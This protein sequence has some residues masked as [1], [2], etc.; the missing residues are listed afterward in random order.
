MYFIYIRQ[1][2]KHPTVFEYAH[3]YLDRGIKRTSAENLWL[4]HQAEFLPWLKVILIFFHSKDRN[5]ATSLLSSWPLCP[6]PAE[7]VSE[8]NLESKVQDIG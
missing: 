4:Q 8:I 7:K 1:L 3:D 6:N 5:S 2:S